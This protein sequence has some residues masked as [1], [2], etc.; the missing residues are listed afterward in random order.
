MNPAHVHGRIAHVEVFEIQP[1]IGFPVVLTQEDGSTVE[2]SLRDWAHLESEL[3]DNGLT[4]RDVTFRGASYQQMQ[5]G[6]S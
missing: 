1:H 5:A 2:M 4:E 6:R 3:R